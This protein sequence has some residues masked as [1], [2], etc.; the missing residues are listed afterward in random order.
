MTLP[1]NI[2]AE[3]FFSY[4]IQILNPLL[5]LRKREADMLEAF[6][7]VH[8]ANRHLTNVNQLLFSFHSLRSIRESLDMSVA[9]FNNHKLQLRKKQIFIGN[10]INPLI[11]KYPSKGKLDIVF[12][13][14]ILN[15]KTDKQQAKSDSKQ[16]LH[17]GQKTSKEVHL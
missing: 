17:D 11:T 13:I 6:L 3:D 5:K 4:Y 8:Y 2:K 1:L 9:S 7:R 14:N 15:E 12:S 10:S 16:S